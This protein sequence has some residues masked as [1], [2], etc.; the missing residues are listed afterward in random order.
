M[1]LRTD[2]GQKMQLIGVKGISQ[3]SKSI[4][5]LTNVRVY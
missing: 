3:H 4:D 1:K 5:F 2:N